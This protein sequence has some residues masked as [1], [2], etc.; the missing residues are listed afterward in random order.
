MLTPGTT[1]KRSRAGARELTPGT[2]QYCVWYRQTTGL[3]LDLLATLDRAYPARKFSWLYVVVDHSKI[4]QAHAV[5]KWLVA[6]PRFEVLFLPT[7]CPKAH[8]MERACGEV[9]D[10]CTR[11]HTRKRMRTLVGDVEPPLAVTGPWP[12]ALSELYYTPEVTAAVEA[13]RAAETAHEEISQ[14]AA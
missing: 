12:Y 6:H 3:F 14:L 8:P 1:E 4:H 10:T 9:H 11:T 5:D 13:L 7:Y 2:T